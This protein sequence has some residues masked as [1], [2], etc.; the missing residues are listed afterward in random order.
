MHVHALHFHFKKME[1]RCPLCLDEFDSSQV[2]SYCLDTSH[3]TVCKD[4]L[5]NYLQFKIDDSFIGSCPTLHCPC[6]HTSTENKRPILNFELWS[7]SKIVEDST[8]LKYRTLAA[9]IL[10]FLCGGCHRYNNCMKNDCLFLLYCNFV[11]A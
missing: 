4:C 6:T 2:T 11:E 1:Q 9:G 10:L 7:T 5:H 8:V 3:P